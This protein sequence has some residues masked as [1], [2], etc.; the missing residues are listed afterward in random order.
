MKLLIVTKLLNFSIDKQNLNKL[1][2]Y[3]F[4]KQEYENFKLLYEQHEQTLD[5]LTNFLIA[6]GIYFDL[7]KRNEINIVHTNYDY[8][9][10][11]GGDGT[12]LATA[13]HFDDS[14]KIIGIKSNHDSIGYLCAYDSDTLSEFLQDICS[15]G[16]KFARVSRIKAKINH[17]ILNKQTITKSALNELLFT[18]LM[19][20]QTARYILEYDSKREFHKSSGIYVSTAVGSTAAIAAS[21]G[22][23]LPIDFL[24]FQFVIREPYKFGT[25]QPKILKGFVNPDIQ[26]FAIYNRCE[27]AILC[28]DGSHTSYTLDYGDV[29]EPIRANSIFLAVKKHRE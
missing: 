15:D 11:V 10:T 23:Y 16:F 12:V 20:G 13:Q 22:E 17:M 7:I 2:Q 14:I 27:K 21:G 4:F 3:D 6:N 9:I 8:I 18:A 1:I 25:C 29:V 24:D 26:I 5:R 19:P 28:L